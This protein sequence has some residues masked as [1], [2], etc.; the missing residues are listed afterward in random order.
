MREESAGK[1]L[2]VDDEEHICTL[3]KRAL[4]MHGF[5]V[6]TTT[7]PEEALKLAEEQKFDVLLADIRMPK[8]DGMELATRVRAMHPDIAVVFITGFGTMEMAIRA[9]E[10][11]ADGFVPKPFGV[12]DIV[13][14]VRQ[15]VEKRKVE[16]EA[17]R[18]DQLLRLFEVTRTI[19][20]TLDLEEV[21]K[22]VLDKAVEETG[23]AGGSI[24]LF[25]P[26]TE[27]LVVKASRNLPEEH[28]E[29]RVRLG[30]G[31]AG[32][33]ASMGQPVLVKDIG[34][35]RRF[36]HLKH[37]KH[38]EERS[39]IVVPIVFK[40]KL[41]GTINLNAGKGREFSEADLK[42]VDIL[43]GQ[44]AV[45]I[46][47]ARL[48]RD[49]QDAYV[50]TILALSSAMEA[51]DPYTR[52]HSER[53]AEISRKIALEMGMPK[54]EADDLHQA[55]LMHDIGKIGVPDI[56]LQKRGPLN[57]KEFSLVKLHPLI[58][59]QILSPA[60]FLSRLIPGVYHHHERFDGKGYLEGLANGKIPKE[61]RIMA[62]ADAFEAMTSS[63]PYRGALSV[64]E[65]VEE[66]RRGKGTQFDPE[67]VE[68]LIAVLKR[69]QEGGRK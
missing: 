17:I 54:K 53:V 18:L 56:I 57:R 46:E 52:G 38:P 45:A 5:E 11:G 2:V 36:S 8:M 42:L 6:V 41:Y 1:V 13:S 64:E 39:F 47:N 66:L 60:K 12:E 63:R 4:S 34:R 25:D 62:V 49:L 44:A 3:C 55:G 10:E 40:G 58:G 67:A 59:K 43:G 14:A 65:A 27:E 69:E 51:K 35:D 21:C 7:D 50:A 24:M 33:V 23:A 26:E 61:A 15:A 48:Y 30:E 37:G 22:V 9:V 19:T 32:T 20:S 16:V 68:A 31:I 29:A 28:A